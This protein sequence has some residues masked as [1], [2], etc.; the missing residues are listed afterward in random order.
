[1]N[2]P[3]VNSFFLPHWWVEVFEQ[4][5]VLHTTNRDPATYVNTVKFL[6]YLKPL[7]LK[8]A[9][10]LISIMQQQLLTG[11][12]EHIVI[13]LPQIYNELQ[14]LTRRQR[15]QA[16]LLLHELRTFRILQ[17]QADG[18]LQ[19]WPL[20]TDE[21]WHQDNEDIQVE[22]QLAPWGRELLLG[23]CE[24]YADFIRQAQ[25]NLQLRPCCA[26]APL[27]LWKSVWL[28]VQGT[29]QLLYLRLEAAAQ[30]HGNWLNLEHTLCQDLPTLSAG[31]ELASG[32]EP[33][34]G[35]RELMRLLTTLGKKLTEHGCLLSRPVPRT[36]FLD[37]EQQQQPQLLWTL[38]R[39]A[40][41]QENRQAWQQAVC[42]NLCTQ[43]LA[44]TWEQLLTQLVPDRRHKHQKLLDS[45]VAWL[46]R[47]DPA[48]DI[49]LITM[50]TPG[51]PLLDIALFFEWSLRRMLPSL[52]LPQQLVPNIVDNALNADSG[53]PLHTRLANFRR[54]LAEN[55]H[56]AQELRSVPQACLVSSATA[57]QPSATPVVAQQPMTEVEAKPE[58]TT[59]RDTT[60]GE[61]LRKI[62][63]LELQ[64]IA[65]RSRGEY[66]QLERD[67]FASLSPAARQSILEV[68]KHMQAGIFEN[69]LRPRLISF[70]IDNPSAWQ[71]TDAVKELRVFD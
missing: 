28:D 64:K 46:K 36:I 65:A 6:P 62:A 14:L 27:H 15:S 32:K 16:Q 9:S 19:T 45:F 39:Y 33:A 52:A 55:P 23:Y 25:H 3:R 42:A 12:H 26:H 22:L 31:L 66:N 47:C 67:Y 21:V 5:T 2:L 59:A 10:Q 38:A 35:K 53:V 34:S 4:A 13:T 58:P 68:K 40:T 49:K 37:S 51:C 11:T 48:V 29:E 30:Q 60:G 69:H 70:M 63:A 17:A 71:Q 50:L 43:Q 20:F 18:A 61:H 54:W 44:H 56:F 8:L 41:V 7:Q 57:A 24:P 1:M